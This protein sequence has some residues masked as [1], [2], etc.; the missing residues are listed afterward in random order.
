MSFCKDA[1]ILD[2]LNVTIKKKK[3]RKK[4]G[5]SPFK[6]NR[7]YASE[8]GHLKAPLQNSSGYAVSNVNE[9]E[10]LEVTY[11]CFLLLYTPQFISYLFPFARNHRWH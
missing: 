9:E 5:N 11:I 3:E 4:R 7:G 2:Y 6:C 1:I 10:V 8:R